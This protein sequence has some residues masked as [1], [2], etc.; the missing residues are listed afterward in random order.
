MQVK[1]NHGTLQNNGLIRNLQANNIFLSWERVII[2]RLE[3]IRPGIWIP[4][5]MTH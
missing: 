1:F 2:H 3:E 4:V 5:L